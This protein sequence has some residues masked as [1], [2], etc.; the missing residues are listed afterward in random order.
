MK[1]GLKSDK[2]SWRGL[3]VFLTLLGVLLW[4]AWFF[5]FSYE[6]CEDK[7]CFDDKLQ[8]CDR[9]GFVGGDDM[10]FRYVIKGESEGACEVE[11]ELLQGNLNN[12]DSS[13]LE[14]KK[15]T[16]MLPLE[17]LRI[18]KAISMFVMGY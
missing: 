8:D 1:K 6:A 11:V 18:L 7:T 14:G 16:C 9:V 12:A 15:M 13:K 17:L 2:F 5:F 10:I 3:F 4:V